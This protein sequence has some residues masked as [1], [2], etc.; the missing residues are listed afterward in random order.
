MPFH[1][2]KLFDLFDF[3]SWF[4]WTFLN[5]LAHCV[6]SIPWIFLGFEEYTGSKYK[7]IDPVEDALDNPNVLVNDESL[8]FSIAEGSGEFAEGSGEFDDSDD[9]GKKF[10][11]LMGW[12]NV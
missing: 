3:T 1:E 11:H 7:K 6:V 4:D 10:R 8:D 9:S 12:K 2:K 5:F